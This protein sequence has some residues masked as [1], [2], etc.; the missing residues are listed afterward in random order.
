MTV[1]TKCLSGVLFLLV[2]ALGCGRG[3]FPR[4]VVFGDV[5][6]GGKKVDSGTVRFAPLEART[7]LPSTT[8]VIS[9]GQYRIE[10]RGGVP[11]G[12]YRVEVYAQ[13]LTGKKIADRVGRMVEETVPIGPPIYGSTQSPL[14]TEIRANSDGRFDVAI[15]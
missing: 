14:V 5:T 6:C 13:Q 9:N 4:V 12:N 11:L 8:G 2:L 10:F 7:L 1:P 3:D 15:P